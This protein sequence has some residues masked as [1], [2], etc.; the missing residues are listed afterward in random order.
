MLSPTPSGHV[1]Q[2]RVSRGG[3]HLAVVEQLA[4]H[5]QALAE[6]QSAGRKLVT[7]VTGSLNA[8][9]H[10][11]LCLDEGSVEGRSDIQRCSVVKQS[12]IPCFA[13]HRSATEWRAGQTAEVIQRRSALSVMMSASMVE[14]PS[15]LIA[16]SITIRW[17][18][19]PEHGGPQ[20]WQPCGP[21]DRAASAASL[22][23]AGYRSVSISGRLTDMASIET[24]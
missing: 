16:H 19:F 4:D 9:L 6:G 1:C 21:G 13:T 2:M 17:E 12:R 8:K 20:P 7:N 23:I 22:S 11:E 10:E 14:Q 24:C 3:L 15:G 18:S 5:R